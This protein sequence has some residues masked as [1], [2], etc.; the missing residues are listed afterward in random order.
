MDEQVRAILTAIGED[1]EREGLRETPK[2]VR[3]SWEFLTEG[4]RLD[5]REV[6][7]K[8]LFHEDYDEMVVVRDVEF[9][10]VCEHHMLPFVGR[11]HVAYLPDGKVVGLSKIP[12]LIDVFARRLQVQE[13]LTTEVATSL[14]EILEPRG[15]GVVLEAQHFCMMMR[16]VQ[17]QTSWTT[18]SC[19]LGRFKR[20]P[21]TR[22]EFLDLIKKPIR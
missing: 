5:P 18:T 19:M 16:G 6:V 2:R 1:P 7:S 15:V 11:A 4:Y 17:K 10:S 22:G 3:K 20:D 13:R 12:R 8:A 9:Y 21:K 14:M